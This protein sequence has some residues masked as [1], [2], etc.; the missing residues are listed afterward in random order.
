MCVCVCVRWREGDDNRTCASERAKAKEI[1]N[2]REWEQRRQQDGSTRRLSDSPLLAL[3]SAQRS[4][5]PRRT[6]SLL[7]LAVFSPFPFLFFP[8]TPDVNN[9]QRE[10][11]WVVVEVDHLNDTLADQFNRP[12]QPSTSSYYHYSKIRNVTLLLQLLIVP[13]PM[14]KDDGSSQQGKQT[15]SFVNNFT[16]VHPDPM[17]IV[18][19][20]S[21]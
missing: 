8:T 21:V 9:Q 11:R 4:K 18:C 2:S 6:T 3:R 17:S 15:D 10:T 16:P 12:H 5:T 13:Y 19:F 14:H 1:K 20:A 7:T